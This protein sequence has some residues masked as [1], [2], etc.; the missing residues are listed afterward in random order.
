MLLFEGIVRE[1]VMCV[2]VWVMSVLL[3]GMPPD[4]NLLPVNLLPMNLSRDSAYLLAGNVRLNLKF[5]IDPSR[6]NNVK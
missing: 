4:I 1:D 5:L 6:Y 3:S 2:N